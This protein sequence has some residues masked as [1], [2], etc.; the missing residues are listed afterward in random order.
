MAK[1][2]T[3][4]RWT[5]TYFISRCPERIHVFLWRHRVDRR[6]ELIVVADTP[7]YSASSSHYSLPAKKLSNTSAALIA[8]SPPP[9][10]W[11]FLVIP[12]DFFWRRHSDSDLSVCWT[13]FCHEDSSQCVLVQRDQSAGEQTDCRRHKQRPRRD[14]RYRQNLEKRKQN[15]ELQHAVRKSL[16]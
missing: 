2:S 11:T 14:R 6:C 12:F 4:T 10:L 15:N 9:N 16:L 13:A 3:A 5:T 1:D 7:K 8:P